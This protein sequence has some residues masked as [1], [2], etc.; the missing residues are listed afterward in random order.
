ARRVLEE[1][2]HDRAAAQRR[3]LRDGAA[4]HLD[5]RV[6][7]VEQLLD[8]LQDQVGDGEEVAAR[9]RTTHRGGVVHGGGQAHDFCSSPSSTPDML[10]S[11]SS[12]R[13]VGR[14]LPTKSG[15]MGSSRWPRSIITA[16]CTTRGRP[17]STSA[18]SAARMVLPVKS[19]SSTSTTILPSRSTGMS[20]TSS[21]R[22]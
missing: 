8:L 7:E 10:T 15:R 2:G 21:G 5:E 14:F 6:G 20:V 12:S 13:R 19:T 11:T 9:I 18:S 4:P 1:Q 17:K 22:T 3:H 16:S